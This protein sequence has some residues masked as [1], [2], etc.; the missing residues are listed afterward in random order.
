MLRVTAGGEFIEP[1]QP[2]F[3]VRLLAELL[4]HLLPLLDAAPLRGAEIGVLV[5]LLIFGWVLGADLE[6]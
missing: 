6:Q 5:D 1:Q 3:L 2:A 4:Q